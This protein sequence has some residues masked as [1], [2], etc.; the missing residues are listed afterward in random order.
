M[1]AHPFGVVLGGAGRNAGGKRACLFAAGFS[2]RRRCGVGLGGVAACLA[3]R[4][5]LIHPPFPP[6]RGHPC[7][8]RGTRV[9]AGLLRIVGALLLGFHPARGTV[10][11]YI[12]P[13]PNISIEVKNFPPSLASPN[14]TSSIDVSRH[15]I[16]QAAA[17]VGATSSVFGNTPHRV[18]SEIAWRTNIILANLEQTPSGW[19]QSSSYKRLDPTE[20]SGVSYHLGMVLPAIVAKKSWNVPHLVHVD[21]ILQIL[22]KVVG[23]VQRPDL[24]GYCQG[25]TANSLGRLLLEAKGRTNG[26]AQAPI[27]AAI[28]QLNNAPIDVKK[29]VGSAAPRVASL[30]HF[31]NGYWKGYMT[32]PPETL[33]TSPYSDAEFQALIDTA[34]CWPFIEIMKSP[35]GDQSQ[36]Q[37]NHTV[38]I[39]QANIKIS[40][41]SP[42]FDQLK[43]LTF[44]MEPQT[45]VS[46]WEEIPHGSSSLPPAFED[47]EKQS[48][49]QIDEL[50]Q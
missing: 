44:P 14:G 35:P 22:G 38:W 23:N 9:P 10:A 17:E 41:S 42:I 20:K 25:A 49:V 32:D 27:T 40:I 2:R 45:L 28:D 50:K 26:F 12:M 29:L 13:M 48:L 24:V 34:Y 8:H 5:R 31:E 16:C 39:P 1:A 6:A 15:E 37:E 47:G 36:D 7:E 33:V 46:L 3:C 19:K 4:R 21:A 11:L 43:E 30:S 18:V